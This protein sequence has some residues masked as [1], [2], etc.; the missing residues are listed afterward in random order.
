M[1]LNFLRRAGALLLTLSMLVSLLTLPA[2]AAE[3]DT[4]D[5]TSI[6]LNYESLTLKVDDTET[7]VATVFPDNATNRAVTWMSSNGSIATVSSSGKVTAKGIG[8]ATITAM[9]TANNTVT[10]TCTVTVTSVPVTKIALSKTS[11]TLT[12]GSSETLTATITPTTA[13]DKTVTWSSSNDSV[14]TVNNGL[15]T[16]VGGGTA[17]IIARSNADDTIQASCTVTVNAP[18]ESISLSETTLSLVTG[19]T[20]VLIATIT[21]SDANVGSITWVSSDSTVV[22]VT[23]NGD[24]A[25]LTAKKAAA[26]PVVV[27]V[28]AG[29]KT[30][31]CMV[32]VT[33]A[34]VSVTGVSLNKTALTMATRILVLA[35]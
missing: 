27:Y 4:V 20:E 18:V 29:G 34:D 17:T 11:L 31:H 15:V 12:K 22:S 9:S 35:L 30:A 6:T 23:G 8:N 26:N 1:K 33:D 5:V 28:T 16:A 3:G 14:A 13:T 2:G 7:L 10:A 25:V 21:P 32:T 24:F 19:G